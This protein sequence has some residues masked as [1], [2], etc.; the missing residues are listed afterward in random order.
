MG[1]GYTVRFKPPTSEIEVHWRAEIEQSLMAVN[2]SMST[3]LE[4]SEITHF[5]QFRST[6]PFPVSTPLFRLV[7]HSLKLSKAVSGLYDI[8]VQPLVNLWGFGPAGPSSK[9][10]SKALSDALLKTGF[11]KLDLST[12]YRLRKLHPELEIDLSSIAKGYG[13]DQLARLLEGRGVQSYLVEIGGEIRIRGFSPSSQAW[14]VGI[15]R[16]DFGAD[17]R[18]L[19]EVL[20]PALGAVATSGN[21]RNYREQGSRRWSHF[22]D[23][24]SGLPRQTDLV[25]ATI[26]AQDCETADA[27]A[28]IAMLLGLKKAEIFLKSRSP[29]VDYVLIS[30]DSDSEFRILRSFSTE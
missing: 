6:H 13:V 12:P 4:N 16:P 25:S 19:I 20:Q 27:F 15:S 5:N 10:S 7:E 21:Y 9:P 2:A 14:K 24:G 1:T 17:P 11:K 23:P 29:K 18:D 30:Q 28:T 3:Y 8:T 26:L 22:I